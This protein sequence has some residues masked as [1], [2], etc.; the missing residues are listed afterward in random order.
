ML[1][2]WFTCFIL[3]VDWVKSCSNCIDKKL[4]RCG[5]C[6]TL[7]F[8]VTT[9]PILNRFGKQPDIEDELL[10]LDLPPCWCTAQICL[11][12]GA[13]KNKLW[14]LGINGT[15]RPPQ[16]GAIKKSSKFTAGHVVT[17]WSYRFGI[18]WRP[19][20]LTGRLNA[21]LRSTW[22]ESPCCKGDKALKVGPWKAEPSRW[23]H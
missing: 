2:L 10:P 23:Q 16:W 1:Q 12:L 6:S 20:W 4:V 22:L 7:A 18:R 11:Y 13:K 8:F 17:I 9:C 14:T 3:Y 19:P 21:R 5:F 15:K